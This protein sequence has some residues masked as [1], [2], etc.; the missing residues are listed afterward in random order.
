[1]A[2]QLSESE[3]A[4]FLKLLDRWWASYSKRTWFGRVASLP[5]RTER[6]VTAWLD[7]KLQRGRRE[8]AAE[9]LGNKEVWVVYR[10]ASTT[11]LEARAGDLAEGQ[12]FLTYGEAAEFA[13][14]KQRRRATPAAPPKCPVVT[15]TI[16]KE[17]AEG[18]E[19]RTF[20]QASIRIGRGPAA[21]VVLQDDSVEPMHAFLDVKRSVPG[22]EALRLVDNG[23]PVTVRR[24]GEPLQGDREVADGDVLKIGPFE[25][26]VGLAQPTPPAPE[27]ADEW[28][29]PV[30]F[31]F[32]LLTGAE[33]S[34]F[35]A[36][37]LFGGLALLPLLLCA[38]LAGKK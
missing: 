16:R 31:P 34:T 9:Y 18:S 15:L 30:R 2:Q 33:D 24:S 26:Q 19:V 13:R 25:L 8:Q 11:L 21:H 36:M 29:G 7:S 1:M 5:Q 35:S 6:T 20:Q 4:Q 38:R 27:P 17:G 10:R 3:Q 32:T 22:I 14:L 12:A 37:G 28:I 23:S